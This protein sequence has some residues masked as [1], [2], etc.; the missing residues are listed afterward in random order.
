[1]KIVLKELIE[2]SGKK[3]AISYKN[4]E[5]RKSFDESYAKTKMN[6]IKEFIGSNSL[7]V[8]KKLEKG[9]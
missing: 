8:S 1:M 9:N 4:K 6:I 2:K 7:E 3:T 5:K